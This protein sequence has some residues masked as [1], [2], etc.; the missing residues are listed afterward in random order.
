MIQVARTYIQ[1]NVDRAG[2]PKEKNLT[3]M[4][5]QGLKEIQTLVEQKHVV[6]KTD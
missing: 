2:N 4:Q 3:A 1:E 5:E 6:T